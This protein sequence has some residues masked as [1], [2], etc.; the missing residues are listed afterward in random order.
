VSWP[1]TNDG[2]DHDR[3]WHEDD[4]VHQAEG[5]LAAQQAVPISEAA[6]A[7]RA[8]ARDVGTRQRTVAQQVT[9]RQ[10]FIPRRERGPG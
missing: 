9:S 1:A 5:V 7:L 8:Y 2:F 6:A 3:W 10:V 4:V